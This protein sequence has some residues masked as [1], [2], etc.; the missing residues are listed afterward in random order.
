V[1]G[2]ESIDKSQ[3]ERPMKFAKSLY[4]MMKDHWQRTS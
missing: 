1:F 2:W 4:Q 3:L